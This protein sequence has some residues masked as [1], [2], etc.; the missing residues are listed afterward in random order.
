MIT[1]Y[2]PRPDVTVK[3]VKLL[4]AT[5]ASH[6]NDSLSSNYFTSTSDPAP[7]NVHRRAIADCPSVWVPT[8]TWDTSSWLQTGPI[9]AKLLYAFE[10]WTKPISFLSLSPQHPCLLRV[11]LSVTL[12]NTE[13]NLKN[14]LHSPVYQLGHLR[15]LKRYFLKGKCV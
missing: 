13:V 1:L 4:P 15:Y 8:P 11:C 9:Q 3:P 10:E 5:P 6:M 14:N 2:P 12:S 7:V